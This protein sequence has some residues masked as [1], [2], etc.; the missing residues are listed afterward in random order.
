M[1]CQGLNKCLEYEYH[2]YSALGKKISIDCQQE[3]KE[4]GEKHRDLERK[5][6]SMESNMNAV[7]KQFSLLQRGKEKGGEGVTN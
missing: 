2:F 1:E 6:D 4:A 5:F 3:A 7:L